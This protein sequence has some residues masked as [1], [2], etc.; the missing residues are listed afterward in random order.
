M[1]SL[2]RG[3]SREVVNPYERVE[4][5]F[6]LEQ[7]VMC[8]IPCSDIDTFYFVACCGFN[9]TKSIVPSTAAAT[10]GD[11]MQDVDSYQ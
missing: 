1:H 9:F 8:S 11:T 7:L 10:V 2:L 3:Y 4:S 5:W 6:D